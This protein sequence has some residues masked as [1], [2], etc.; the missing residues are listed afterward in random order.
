MRLSTMMLISSLVVP[1]VVAGSA[2]AQP[3]ISIEGSCPTR[4]TFRWDGASPDLPAALIVAEQTGQVTIPTWHCTGT[5]LGLGSRGIR[6]VV[7]TF[8]TGPEGRGE[9]TGRASQALCGLFAQMLVIAGHPC[10][11]SNVVQIPQ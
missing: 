11:T 8:R 7:P 2:C 5:V 4:L 9:V 10:Q 3:V 1:G 6:V